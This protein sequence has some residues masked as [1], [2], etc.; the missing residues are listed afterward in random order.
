MPVL[1]TCLVAAAS[2]ATT[3]GTAGSVAAVPNGLSGSTVL[4]IRHAE[5]PWHGPDLTARGRA[6][7][8]AYPRYFQGFQLD[9]RPVRIDAL[10]AA[11]DSEHSDRS[12][13]TLEPLGKALGVP[14]QQPFKS[15]AV[16]KLVDWLRAGQ[17][18]R[19]VLIAWHHGEI[20][21]LLTA[22]GQEPKAL[23]PHGRWP[24]SAYNRVVVLRFDAA[25]AILPSASK[26]VKE[27]LDHSSH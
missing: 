6:H 22:F 7:A 11:A 8:D 10:V 18:R 21:R 5:K 16:S 25:G 13:L 19:T 23:L 24:S 20:P 27:K 15:H 2:L 26:I 9:G 12:R 17:P 4:I 3:A 14:V 1:S